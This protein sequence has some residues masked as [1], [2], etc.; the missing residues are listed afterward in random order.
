MARIRTI[1]PAFF[2]SEDVCKRTPLARILFE[3]LWC[4]ADRD[5]YLTDSPFQLKT[6]IL[7][8]DDCNVDVLL[9]E[10]ADNAIA[11]PLIRRFTSSGKHY[12]QIL[13]FT[14]HQR[15]HPKEPKSSIPHTGDDRPR[16][17][18][19]INGAQ[20]L[21]PGYIPSSPVGREGDL[22]YGVLGREG[23]LGREGEWER[24]TTRRTGN[25]AN[26]PGSLPRDHMHHSI[27]GPAY[28]LCLKT[29]ECGELMRQ[30]GGDPAKQ[31]AA[32]AEFVATFEQSLGPD[33]APGAFADVEKNFRTWMKSIGRTPVQLKATT[34]DSA[35][36]ARLQAIE[37]GEIRR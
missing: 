12:I 32:V 14:E 33:D 7:P 20:V 13:A 1:K 5:G 17:A 25:G 19:E 8:N 31:K 3:G 21:S 29:W 37:R 15:P 2:T 26:E 6:R 4:E 34:D 36:S 9:W 22:E 24:H 27:C 10:L 11:N 35:L 28:R 30:Y 23:D 18:V 16:P